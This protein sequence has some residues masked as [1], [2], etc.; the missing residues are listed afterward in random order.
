[1]IADFKPV[2][3]DRVEKARLAARRAQRRP[4]T[5]RQT[6]RA[7]RI[8]Q[9]AHPHAALPRTDEPLAKAQ[10]QRPGGVGVDFETNGCARRFHR[11]QHGGKRLIAVSQPGPGCVVWRRHR[12]KLCEGGLICKGRVPARIIL[13]NLRAKRAFA[14]ARPSGPQRDCAA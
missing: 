11:G 6:Q 10:P 13:P 3:R 14:G 8:H 5:V 2:Q 1:M 12:R 7:E 4:E 9:H